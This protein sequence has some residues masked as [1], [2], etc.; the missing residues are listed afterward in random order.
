MVRL[1]IGSIPHGGPIELFLY[2]TTC[3]TKVMVCVILSGIM[4]AKES[5]LLIGKNS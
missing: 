1:V 5:M 3:I 2:S 4:H